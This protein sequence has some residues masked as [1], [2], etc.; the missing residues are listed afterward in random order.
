MIPYGRQLI[1]QD[2]IDQVV[3]I[4]NSEYLT[5]GPI[6]DRFEEAIC[7]QVNASYSVAVN[8][9]TSALHI[10][11]L[12]LG[13]GRGD[14][15]WTVSNTFVASANCGLYCGAKVDFVDIDPTSWNLSIPAL[16]SKLVEAEHK[17]TLPKVLVPVHFGGQPTEQELIWKLA[18]KYDIHVL[19]DAS[20]SLGA[21][22]KGELVGS[23]R[24]S[25]ITI[26]S[27]HPVKMIT[28]GEGGIATTN[29]EE[30]YQRMKLLRSHGITR[31]Q[32][33]FL[34]SPGSATIT[35]K[36]DVNFPLKESYG[37]W[38][39]EQQCLGFNYRITDI[40]AAL[41]LSQLK[42]L[43]TFVDFR[44]SLA[45]KY[46]ENLN[47]LPILLPTL[48]AD[49]LSSWHLFVIRLKVGNNATYHKNVFESLRSETSELIF[50]ICQFTFNRIIEV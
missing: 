24:W 36:Q 50:I 5:Q 21:A 28:T 43:K 33:N 31:D 18:K 12:A 23:C 3:E 10:A 19:E 37:S 8:S 27:F 44:T 29:S 22:R 25:D 39:Y 14:R 2:D 15:L 32:N 46:C 6:V 45:N 17:G 4:L 42:K 48:C 40:Q 11:C 35:N 16:T 9:G 26:F 20:H 7:R 1:N 41:G 13:L 30:L 47:E 34:L 49:N 38:Q